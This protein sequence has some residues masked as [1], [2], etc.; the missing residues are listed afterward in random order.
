MQLR[1]SQKSTAAEGQ[2]SHRVRSGVSLMGPELPAHPEGIQ[3]ELAPTF[4]AGPTN[5]HRSRKYRPPSPEAR[6][7][8]MEAGEVVGIAAS[9]RCH[10]RRSPGPP[11]TGSSPS[12]DR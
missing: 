12:V 2:P 9:T 1:F 8:F 10:R 5:H 3:P 6:A 7:I 11:S 4:T